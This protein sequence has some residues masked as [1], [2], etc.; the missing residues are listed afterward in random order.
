VIDGTTIAARTYFLTFIRASV[1][2][3]DDL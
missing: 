2:C 1:F 3:S